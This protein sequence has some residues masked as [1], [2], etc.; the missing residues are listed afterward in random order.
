LTNKE[1]LAVL[2]EYLRDQFEQDV[3]DFV[4]KVQTEL[5]SDIFGI[6]GKAHHQE[7]KLWREKEGYWTELFPE[8]T[9]NIEVELEVES[10]GEIGN[11]TL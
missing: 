9:I 10:V 5:K 4:A 7:N 11:V 3:I 6:G 1:N 8:L 2:G